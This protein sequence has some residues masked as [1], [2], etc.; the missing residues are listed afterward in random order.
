MLAGVDEFTFKTYQAYIDTDIENVFDE[1]E[2]VSVK[3]TDKTGVQQIQED[4]CSI[5]Y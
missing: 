1:N 5:F 3:K 4:G 2:V